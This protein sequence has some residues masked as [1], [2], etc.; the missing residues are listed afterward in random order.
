MATEAIRQLRPSGRAIALFLPAAAAIAAML[1]AA[2]VAYALGLRVGSAHIATAG[3][4]CVPNTL[5]RSALLPGTHVAVSPLPGTYT[6]SPATEISMLGAPPGA[7]RTLRVIGSSTGAHTG[8]LQAFS[9]GD[10]VAFVPTT[11]FTPGEAVTVRGTV[12]GSRGRI[13][14]FAYRFT[15]A[16]QDN[17]LYS[18]S[19]ALSQDPGEEQHFLSRPDL[20]PPELV[21]TARSS[22]SAAGDIFAAPYAGHGPSGPMIFDE[23][24]NLVWFHPLPKGV[25]GANLQVQH[26]EGKTVLTWW[27]GRIT[28]Q[29]FGQGEEIIDD[30]TYSQ[31]GHVL[32]GNGYLADLHEFEI[33]SDGTAL[34]T[35]L[36]PIECDLS[37]YGGPAVGAA[38]DSIFQEVDLRTGLVRREWHSLDH[39][40]PS[41]SFSRAAGTSRAWPQDYF[42]M[43]SVDQVAGG[44]TLISARNTW[45]LYVLSTT[46]GQI[47]SRIGGRHSTVRLSA[48]A[49]T[50]F[51][52]DATVLPNGTISVFDN[53]AVPVVHKQSRAIIL[54]V[55]AA[56][57]TASLIAQY[58]HPHPL[59]SGSQGNVQALSN[60]DLFV[61]W[62]SQPYFSEFSAGGALLYDAHMHG[63]YQSYRAYR[64]PWTGAPSEAPAVA[65]SSAG[66]GSPL[67]VHASWN[68][69]TRTAAWAVLAGPS[70]S[71]LA[72]VA[73]AARTGFETSVNTPGPA[74]YVAVEALD[75]SGNV[76]GISPTVAG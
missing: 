40:S 6:A 35:V 20:T 1:L 41:E 47:T 38:T 29:G 8:S 36:H 60:G 34:L 73:S 18:Y 50:A 68:G 32:A 51:Q 71:E 46:T 26:D 27:Q 11:T 7:L 4:K 22:A 45:T 31:I 23:A 59:S 9:Q 10:G 19:P 37:A 56:R 13:V 64:F 33:R 3:V 21:V 66:A 28:P 53:G 30:S 55:D 54:A 2:G 43:N 44:R 52:H 75:G 39:V 63:S 14:P 25:E 16:E 48:G 57:G 62:G 65:V 24:G 17:G 70:P 49:A 72:P 5:N 61:G 15:V 42:H 58:L 12:A 69:D 67:T 74:A 76:L